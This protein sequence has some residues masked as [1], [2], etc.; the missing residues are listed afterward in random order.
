[1]LLKSKKQFE[2]VN[3][4]GLKF[5]RTCVVQRTKAYIDLGSV[6]DGIDRRQAEAKEVQWDGRKLYTNLGTVAKLTCGL[7]HSLQE[8][9]IRALFLNSTNSYVEEHKACS[10]GSQTY[11]S[12]LPQPN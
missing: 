8:K 10:S 12:Y 11:R 7:L 9:Q 1:M 4:M 5:T 6:R 2:A 3:I